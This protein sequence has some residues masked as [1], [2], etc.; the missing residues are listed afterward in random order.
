MKQ[1][2]ITVL[3]YRVLALALLG[4]VLLAGANYFYG[5]RLNR[6]TA[7]M[8][9]VSL[10]ASR[11]LYQV[12]NLL[13]EQNALVS[14]A[15]GIP[16][17]AAIQKSQ[18]QFGALAVQLDKSYEKLGPLAPDP[19]LAGL[20]KTLKENSAAQRA[21][22]GNVFTLAAGFQQT[23]A[24]AALQQSFLPADTRLNQTAIAATTRA[25]NLVD[26]KPA[27]ILQ[28]VG[29]SIRAGLGLSVVTLV[30]V[31]GFS[32]WTVQRRILRPLRRMT[33]LL[34]EVS[35]TN[36]Q[37]AGQISRASQSLAEGASE[38]AASIE[39]TSASLE[40]L[41]S[42][43][44]RNADNAHQATE[45]TKQTRTAADKGTTDM[46]TMTAAMA[47]IK[48][49]SDETAKIIKT[50]DEIAFQTN[51][52][53]LNA[54]VEAARA[55]EAGMGF[56]VV[57]DEVRNLAQRSAQ[58]ARETSEKIE[59][60]LT[61]TAQGVEVSGKVAAT[62]SEITGKVRQVD[63]LIVAVAG[64]SREQTQGIGQINTAV[65]QMDK[66]TQSNAANSEETAAAAQE[67]NSQ[68]DNLQHSVGELLALVGGGSKSVPPAIRP[69]ASPTSGKS[70]SPKSG[71]NRLPVAPLPERPAPELAAAG[72]SRFEDF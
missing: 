9:E 38:Q 30:V 17:I 48:V 22:A 13:H 18:E 24:L 64:A 72:G 12:S 1:Q 51:I 62:L 55:G 45:L 34:Q 33:V 69:N 56:A 65:S 32:V 47:A 39:E 63:E 67:L 58:A 3:I 10:A 31:I 40:E 54:A 21:A 42:M 29:R 61:R 28:L 7:T 16:D 4:V 66:V 2:T 44:Q 37:T 36:L 59:N 26:E 71:G 5:L 50:I 27:E 11:E 23:E 52:L 15:P 25:L 57:A 43:T 68:A 14:A 20:I 49:S 60:A 41:A 35:G 19:E 46:A 6:A 8:R 70:Q 53:A